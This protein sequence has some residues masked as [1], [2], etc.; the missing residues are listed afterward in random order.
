LVVFVAAGLLSNCARYHAQPISP[1]A[2]EKAYRNRGLA[3]PGLRAFV[4]ANSLAKLVQWPPAK[5]DLEALT[6]VALYY[7][8][9]LDVARARVKAAEAR[10][11]TAGGCINPSLSTAAGYTNSPESAFVFRFS[12]AFTIET[13]GKRGYRILQAQKLAEVARLELSEAAWKT[14]SHLRA[15][16]VEHLLARRKLRLLRTRHILQSQA[17]E[18]L[19]K[20]LTVGEASLPD[21]NALKIGLS[22]VQIALKD[23]Q[24]QVSES[25]ANLAAAVSVQVVALANIPLDWQE[26]D[27]PPALA[28]LPLPRIQQAGLLNR[29][30]VRRALVE[31]AAAE[32]GLQLEVARQYPDIELDPGYDFDEGHHKFTFGPAFS[33]PILNRNQGPIAE[34]QAARKEAE[35]RFVALQARAIA[36][37]E[38]SLARYRAAVEK[39]SEA[40]SKLVEFQQNKEKAMTLAVSAGEED[41][42]TLTETRI[43]TVAAAVTQLE[44]LRDA[45]TALGTLEDAVQRSLTPEAKP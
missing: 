16:L 44:A 22:S 7:S 4:E 2:L 25:L 33:L 11:I 9:A 23:A 26:L 29:I 28:D 1:P 8:P 31:Y 37:M 32:A 27:K 17:V 20:R 24:G 5:L 18:M 6:L 35:A 41:R 34:A 38:S 21:V 10:I 40:E 12:P 42:L 43:Q 39:L 13:A 14:R 3:D 30:D 19:E 45:Q 36:D 15:A